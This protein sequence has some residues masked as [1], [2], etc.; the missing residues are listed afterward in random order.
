MRFKTY[1]AVTKVLTD[2]GL[3]HLGAVA[4]KLICI[5]PTLV[6]AEHAPEPTGATCVCVCMCVCVRRGCGAWWWCV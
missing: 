2:F 3:C 6:I 1:I 5:M 4:L